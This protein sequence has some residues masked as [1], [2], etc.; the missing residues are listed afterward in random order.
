MDL[1]VSSYDESKL[2]KRLNLD[3]LPMGNLIEA[4]FR[5]VLKPAPAG[6]YR[7]DRVEPV[8]Q[9]D[10]TYYVRDNDGIM[11][12]I[13][14]FDEIKTSIYDKNGKVV[15]PALFMKKKEKLLSNKPI[16]PYRGILIAEQIIIRCIDNFVMWRGRKYNRYDR[17]EKHF[18]DNLS[19]EMEF[20]DAIDSI[21]FG[22]VTALNDWLGTDSWNTYLCSRKNSSIVVDQYGDYRIED[23]TRRFNEGTITL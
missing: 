3:L 16:L 9:P 19:E 12:A 14:V 21:D 17:I 15:I 13:A 5:D 23:W 20:F 11:Q 7:A 6:I 22:G 18:A 2:Q 8:I 10:Q 4:Q 1:L